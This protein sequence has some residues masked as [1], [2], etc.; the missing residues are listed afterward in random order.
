[1]ETI[2]NLRKSLPSPSKK[3]FTSFKLKCEIYNKTNNKTAIIAQFD[4][5]NFNF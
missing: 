4:F 2:N 1:M 3:V 5:I